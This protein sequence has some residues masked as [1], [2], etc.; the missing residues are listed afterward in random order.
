MFY[1]THQF[2]E[3]FFPRIYPSELLWAKQI[4]SPQANLLFLQQSKAE[5]RHALAVAKSL[6]PYQESLSSSEYLD[7]ITAAL[8]H[9]CGKSLTKIRLWQRVF[10][11][12]IQQLPQGIWSLLKN[13]PSLLAA[14]LQI[15]DHHARWGSNL[16]QEIGLNSRVC[17]LI[18]DHHSP[19]S[20]LGQMLYRA[21]NQH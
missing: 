12:L 18:N 16:A 3:A 7:L 4:L 13:G 15:A 21:D 2:I 17:L 14:P 1:R 6:L 9:D 10:I 20:K 11:V 5:Q 8:L 19:N